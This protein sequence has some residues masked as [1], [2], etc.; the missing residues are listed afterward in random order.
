MIAKIS[1][2]FYEKH[3]AWI[4][5]ARNIHCRLEVVKQPSSPPSHPGASL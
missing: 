3:F 2:D 4:F 1:I 5:P